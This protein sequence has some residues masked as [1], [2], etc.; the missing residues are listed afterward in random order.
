M[1]RIIKNLIKVFKKKPH[2][3]IIF[4]YILQVFLCQ[5][6]QINFK[7]LLNIMYGMVIIQ[8]VIGI[9]NSGCGCV[10]NQAK[11]ARKEGE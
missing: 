2:Y 1:L 9:I 10:P 4:C 6:Q 3:F 7:H 11:K 5:T 8:N